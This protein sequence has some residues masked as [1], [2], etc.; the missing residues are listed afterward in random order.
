MT[1]LQNFS[2][3]RMMH[4][5]ILLPAASTLSESIDCEGIPATVYSTDTI[6]LAVRVQNLSR[7]GIYNVRV[8]LEGQ[9]MFPKEEIFVGNMDAGT[10]AEGTMSIYVGTRTMKAA[11][12]DEGTDEDVYK[13]QDDDPCSFTSDRR[14]PVQKSFLYDTSSP[15]AER[16]GCSY[17]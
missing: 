17:F 4:I 2:A 15:S 16:R 7:T 14:H 12:Q 13:R 5:F 6:D 3:L 1:N 10:M 9:G 11:G 8:D